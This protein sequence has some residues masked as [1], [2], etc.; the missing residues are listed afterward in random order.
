MRLLL[1][2]LAV[3]LLAATPAAADYR[4]LP[5]P[6]VDWFTIGGGQLLTASAGNLTAYA[7]DGTPTPI[8]LPRGEPLQYVTASAGGLSVDMGPRVAY[9]RAF[10]G[11]WQRAPGPYPTVRVSGSRVTSLYHNADDT[12]GA[13]RIIDLRTGKD[14]RYRINDDRPV[15]G[16]VV[17]RYFAYAINWAT[18]RETVIVR[19]VASGREVY[20]IRLDV[21][22]GFELL[23]GGRLVVVV[24]GK[25]KGR[26]RVNVATPA[27]PRLRTIRE[28]RL[29][30]SNLGFTNDAMAL[31]HSDSQGRG[32]V[33]L[34]DFKG[35]LT[36][37]TPVL[38]GIDHVAYDG[39]TLAFEVG[40]CVFTGPVQPGTPVATEGCVPSNDG[41][42]GG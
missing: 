6:K 19:S 34:M 38:E 9:Y 41:G 22:T 42:T 25:R 16:Q 36:P 24:P 11:E 30:G 31:V 29:L 39:R 37:V 8:A 7:P 26:Y 5:G 23:S 14:R 27:R 35:R 13:I 4:R 12:G 17:G 33:A 1:L 15:G 20:R 40:D 3:A 2:G 28:L 32:E 18:G 21:A 10:D